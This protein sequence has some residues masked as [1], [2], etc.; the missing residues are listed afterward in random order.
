MA[1]SKKINN[2]ETSS[3][4]PLDIVELMLEEQTSMKDVHASKLIVEFLSSYLD[5]S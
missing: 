2:N 4:V 3:Q 5:T 1:N